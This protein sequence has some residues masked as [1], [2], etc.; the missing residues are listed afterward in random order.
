MAALFSCV[1]LVPSPYSMRFAGA[2][3]LQGQHACNGLYIRIVVF[4]L[5]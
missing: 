1:E 4:D 5:A 3:Y 2:L